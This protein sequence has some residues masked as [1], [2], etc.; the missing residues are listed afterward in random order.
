LISV[1]PKCFRQIILN[2]LTNAIKFSGEDCRIDISVE[3]R[4]EF[5]AFSFSDNGIGIPADQLR[6]VFKAFHQ[7]E[8]ALSKTIEGTGL[9]LSIT[10]ALVEMHHGSIDIE[11]EAGKGTTIHISLPEQQPASRVSSQ[12]AA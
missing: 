5:I 8:S 9:G 7:I 6:E 11:S 4:D 3:R 10:K 12:D 2:I 1:D